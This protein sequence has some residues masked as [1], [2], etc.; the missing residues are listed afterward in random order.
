MSEGLEGFETVFVCIDDTDD[1]T[2]ETSTG[3][4]SE[5][6]ANELQRRYG[7]ALR[8]GITR[9]QLLLD[10]RVPY[11][12]HNSSMCFDISLPR[13]CV[14]EVVEVCWECTRRMRAKT[15]NPGIC[16]MA[17]SDEAGRYRDLVAFGERAK[18]DYISVDEARAMAETLPEL[19]LEGEGETA[20]GMVGALAGVGLR[21][22]GEDG[23]FRGKWDMTAFPASLKFDG[24][25]TATVAECAA[26][27][28][29][30]GIDARFVDFDGAPLPDGDRV[31]LIAD[32]KPILRGG[33][34]TLVCERKLNGSWRPCTK[35]SFIANAGKPQRKTACVHF[36]QDPDAEEHVE[37]AELKTCGSCLYRVFTQSGMECVRLTPVR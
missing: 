9:H 19:V 25:N 3:A 18:A 20:Q 31:I 24:A 36:E 14:R 34:F 4:V 21:F 32:A 13:G 29:Q 5:A 1:L 23:R 17:A 35:K 27:F 12:S 26:S 11:T 7:N 30:R 16:V 33:A 2:K 28:A 22:G 6:I 15:A 10:E 37:R 8:A